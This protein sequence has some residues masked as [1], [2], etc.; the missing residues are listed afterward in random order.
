VKP[1]PI[2]KHTIVATTSRDAGAFGVGARLGDGASV[3]DASYHFV[4]RN[5]R[6][7]RF[8]EK[9]RAK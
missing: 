7:R 1:P 5:R 8:A 2:G 4:G 9:V 6:E 3:L